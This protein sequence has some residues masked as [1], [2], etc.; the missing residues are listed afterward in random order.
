MAKA[1]V[2]V[3]SV[4]KK[5]QALEAELTQAMDALLADKA[6]VQ[7]KADE[8]I[9]LID[10]QIHTANE[11]YHGATGRW[12]VS[13]PSQPKVE[14]KATR[15]RLTAEQ[16]GDIAKRIA[17]TDKGIKGGLSK[18]EVV[19]KVPE[20]AKVLSLVEFCK[21]FGGI[22]LVTEGEKRAMKYSLK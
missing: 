11:W 10:D 9:K 4:F 15:V 19:E 13:P 6:E 1:T 21:E 8:S 14:G 12:Y 5:V 7:R 16:K 20:A 22:E 17:A 2:N 18:A 3:E